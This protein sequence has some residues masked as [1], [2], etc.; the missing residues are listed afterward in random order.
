MALKSKVRI[1]RRRG[2]LEYLVD[3]LDPTTGRRHRLKAPTQE[4]AELLLAT[5]IQEAHQARPVPTVDPEITLRDYVGVTAAEAKA[6]AKKAGVLQ[7]LDSDLGRT[8]WCRRIASEV[9]PRTARSYEETWSRYVKPALGSLKIRAIHRGHVKRLLADV[10]AVLATKQKTG[11]S[12]N[13]K[14]L[15]RAT[16]SRILSDA[17]D[18]GLIGINPALRTGGRKKGVDSQSRQEKTKQIRPMSVEQFE[19][20][21]VVAETHDSDAV[22]YLLM[23][24]AGLRP[25]EALALRWED[26]DD[27][28]RTLLVERAVSLG[29]IKA[30]KTEKTRTV[31][32]SLRL[33]AALRHRQ[34]HVE[35]EA[36]MNGR[37]PSPWIFPSSAGKPRDP[38]TVAKT[39]RLLLKRAGLPR[40]RLYDLRHTYASH[41]LADGAPLTYVADQ[42]GHEKPTTTLQHY[43]H[44]LPSGDKGY[45]DRLAAIRASVIPVAP[46]R[47]TRDESGTSEGSGSARF[48]SGEPWRNR[49]SNLLIKSQLLC[50]LS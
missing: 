22:S 25:G 9:E 6:A 44:W 1:Q 49:T 46:D 11:L 43:A 10:K 37:E 28:N 8:G 30:T 42:L 19:R 7:P 48:K 40:F 41:L 4:A 15:I 38:S 31:D 2:R 12:K 34:D 16:L 29:R 32:L 45:V 39:F 26:V 47:G 17:Q 18:D 5:K 3:Y 50:Q 20:F 14:R 35:A 33:M 23:G 27:A 24:E 36:L 13:S 21:R